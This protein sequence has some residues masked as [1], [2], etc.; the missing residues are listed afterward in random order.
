M[1]HLLRNISST[2][3]MSYKLIDIKIVLYIVIYDGVVSNVG[4]IAMTIP[5]FKCWFAWKQNLYP[6]TQNELGALFIP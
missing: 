5:V 4:N 2:Y 3:V 1:G 6:R